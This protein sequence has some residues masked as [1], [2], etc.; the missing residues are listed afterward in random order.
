MFG[1]SKTESV[2][3]A[4][5]GLVLMAGVASAMEPATASKTDKGDVL[6][7]A[8]G[9]TLYTFDKDS[10]GKSTCNGKCAENWPILKA[11]AE[12]KTM[13]KWSVIKRDDGNLQWAYEGKP[14]YGW[15][16]DQKPGDTTGDGVNG[17][18]HVAKP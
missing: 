8:K 2:L 6:A 16:K 3:A 12:A 10:A 4:M 11:S 14:L 13:G 15:V 7:D 17:V 9:M 1:I 5:V 18:W